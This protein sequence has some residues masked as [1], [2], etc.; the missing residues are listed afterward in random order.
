MN[1]KIVD[2]VKILAIK[3]SRINEQL[4]QTKG[5]FQEKLKTGTNQN[6]FGMHLSFNV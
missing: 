1:L 2:S 4:T 5:G 6:S 3:L